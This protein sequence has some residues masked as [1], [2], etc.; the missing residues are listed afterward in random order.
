MRAGR[1][2]APLRGG[3]ARAGRARVR[4]STPNASRTEQEG[5]QDAEA[6]RLRPRHDR[7]R[8]GPAARLPHAGGHC[9]D[10]WRRPAR[11]RHR[12]RRDDGRD[13]RRR[14]R[15]LRRDRDLRRGRND[16]RHHRRRRS[17]RLHDR[18]SRDRRHR[19]HGADPGSDGHRPRGVHPLG[20]RPGRDHRG[21]RTA[22][23]RDGPPA[24]QWRPAFRE[25]LE[26]GGAHAAQPGADARRAPRSTGS[27]AR[28]TRASPMPA[29]SRRRWTARGSEGRGR[30]R[31]RANARPPGPGGA[32]DGYDGLDRC[33]RAA[34]GDDRR[35]C[36]GCVVPRR[37]R[38]LL[39]VPS[40]QRGVPRRVRGA[41]ARGREP[42]RAGDVHAGG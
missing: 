16:G 5:D 11:W 13:D 22:H 9:R 19:R 35:R 6:R 26:P 18:W 31:S 32:R 27:P 36:D 42:G 7:A 33:A 10:H 25:H 37:R 28:P 4:R 1:P 40:R 38:A 34:G 14:R 15:G 29:R 8:R 41:R 2:H 21:G 3:P 17:R 20:H 30:G 24:A 39:A 23:G 12:C